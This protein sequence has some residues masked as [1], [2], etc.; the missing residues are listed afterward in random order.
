MKILFYDMGSYLYGDALEALKEMGHEV[1]TVYYHFDDRYNDPFFCERFEKKIKEIDPDFIFSINFF[2]L[3]ATAAKEHGLLYISWSCDSPLAAELEEYFSYDTNRIWLFDREEVK[4][5]RRKGYTRVYYSPL[6]AHPV[7]EP[8]PS[9]SRYACD[10]S[11]VGSLYEST[12]EG[13]LAPLDEYLRGYLG[14]LLDVQMSLYGMD[15][16]TP[17]LTDEIL[18]RVNAR[19]AAVG[20]GTTINRKGLA[21]AIQ[22]QITF[23]ERVTLID[24]LGDYFDTRFYSTKPYPFESKVRF[25]GPVKYHTQMPLVFRNSRLNLCPTLRSI[26]SGIPLRSL[27]IMASG[28]VLMSSYQPELAE[29]FTDGEDMILYQSLEEAVD[30]AS[31]YLAHEEERAAIAGHALP[32]IRE[33]FSYRGRLEKILDESLH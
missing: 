12:L 31:W 24:T 16:L 29:Y 9:D 15:I 22:K 19:Y 3:V 28:G 26:V 4:G 7:T 1:R 20:S 25:C 10:V 17:S 18:D 13:L 23:A 14:G 32:I 11:F 8:L 21:F 5:Y 33:Q 30:K 2:P 27:D 6:A